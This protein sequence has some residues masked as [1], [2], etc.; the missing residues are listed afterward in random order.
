MET[1]PT[2]DYVLTKVIELCTY[3][4]SMEMHGFVMFSKKSSQ[5]DVTT[6]GTNYGAQFIAANPKLGSA[7]RMF[8]TDLDD[9]KVVQSET[10]QSANLQSETTDNTT[11]TPSVEIKIKEEPVEEQSELSVPHEDNSV[12]STGEKTIKAEVESES[13]DQPLGYCLWHYKGMNVMNNEGAKNLD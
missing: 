3:L 11:V 1:N 7:F 6:C 4:E 10:R 9:A 8:C 2:S 13:A 5:I 12:S